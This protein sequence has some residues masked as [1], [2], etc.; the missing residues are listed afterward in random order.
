MLPSARASHADAPEG[1]FTMTETGFA[2]FSYEHVLYLPCPFLPGVGRRVKRLVIVLPH[3]ADQ[4]PG[5]HPA[6]DTKQDDRAR[7]GEWAVTRRRA[8]S[9]AAVMQSLSWCRSCHY[10]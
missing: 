2:S 4:C 1:V 3:I 5:G 7:R 9:V 8:G 6:H 10:R